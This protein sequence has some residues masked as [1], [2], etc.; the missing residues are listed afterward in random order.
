MI[1]ENMYQINVGIYV[2][3]ESEHWFLFE[4]FNINIEL[5]LN[6]HK[7]MTS[8]IGYKCKILIEIQIIEKGIIYLLYFTQIQ[9]YIFDITYIHCPTTTKTHFKIND[10]LSI[11][12][13]RVTT[14]ELLIPF[15]TKLVEMAV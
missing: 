3:C 11:K 13:I 9:S 4:R 10:S 12:I 7:D 1:V 6:I 14:K 15:V 2:S 8:E 5:A